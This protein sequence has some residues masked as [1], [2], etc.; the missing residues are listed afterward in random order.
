MMILDSEFYDKVQPFDLLM[1]SGTGIVSSTIRAAQGKM[2]GNSEFSHVDIVVTSE[3]LPQ[4]P[5]LKPGRKYTLGSNLVI[6]LLTDGVKD[7][8]TNTTKLGVQIRD[9]E[10]VVNKFY[11]KNQGNYICW[12]PLTDNPWVKS[13][14]S[15]KKII[16]DMTSFIAQFGFKPY[17]RNFLDILGRIHKGARKINLQIEE[18]II[19]GIKVLSTVG[20]VDRV[21]SRDIQSRSFSCVEI[22]V[23]IYQVIGVLSMKLD[24]R[25]VAPVHFITKESPLPKVITDPVEIICT[26]SRKLQRRKSLKDVILGL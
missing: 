12:C 25:E 21:D 23:M 5:Q 2:L 7:V 19:D 22:V 18:K 4:I 20:L 8:R 11:S 9:L 15:K 13:E 6:P 24:P 14:K 16:E 10:E 26:G 3:V 1:Y 17:E